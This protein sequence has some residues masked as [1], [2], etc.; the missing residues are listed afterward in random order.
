M[1]YLSNSNLCL[2]AHSSMALNMLGLHAIFCLVFTQ[3][4]SFSPHPF[5][6]SP[7]NNTRNSASRSHEL[8]SRS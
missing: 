6:N 5:R 2:Q 3:V 8:T 1:H 7:T 4:L